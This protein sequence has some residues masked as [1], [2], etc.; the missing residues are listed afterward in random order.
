MA[1][2]DVGAVEALLC[3]GA[4]AWAEAAD[5]C[6]LVVS[7]CMAVLIVFARESL[8]VVLASRNGTLLWPFR[9]M[10]KHVCLEILEDAATVWVW[11]ATLLVDLVVGFDGAQGG[12]AL[13]AS[14]VNG[15]DG[16]SAIVD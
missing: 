16:G 5:H 10:S 3:G 14:R 4:R 8:G 12:T 9:L 13:G 6:S 7:Q 1:L 2:E 15:R 11:A